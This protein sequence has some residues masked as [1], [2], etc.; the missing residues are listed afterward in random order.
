MN[1]RSAALVA[2]MTLAAGVLFAAAAGES[3]AAGEDRLAAVGFHNAGYPIVDQTVTVNALIQRPGHVPTAF[4]EQTL[5]AEMQE[6]ANIDIVFEEVPVAQVR[7]KTNLLFASREFPDMIFV[8]GVN[9]RLLW[10]AAQAGDVWA[11]N[12]LVDEY[13][14]NWKRAFEERPVIRNAISMPDGNYYSLPYYREILNDFGIRDIQAI[15]VDWLHTLGLEMPTTTEELYQTLK[16]FRQGIDDGTLPADS[17]PWYFFFHSWVG[18][19]WEI[20]NAFGLWMK[21]QGAGSQRYLS[22]NNGTVEFG[23]TDEKLK[24][25]VNYLHRLLSED[26]IPEEVF[27]DAWD[28]YLAKTR[29]V[30]PI[31][32]MWGSYF[33]VTPVEEWFD[34]LPPVAGPAGVQRFRSQPV[35]LQKNQF[36][37]FTKFELPEVMVRFI[38]A[39]ADDDFSVQASYG[40]PMIEQ[41]ADGTRTVVGR[42]T[43]WYNHGPHNHFPSYISK[44]ASDA[45]RWT[46]EQGFRDQ[47]VNEVFAPHLWPQDRHFAYITFNDEEQEELSILQT[48]IGDYVK[49]AIAGWIVDGNVDAEWDDYLKQLDRIDLPKAMEIYQAAYDRF[50]GN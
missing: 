19:E 24:D 8:A 23:A 38:D 17:I 25:A 29:S 34:P 33:I 46:G 22:V 49:R 13:A 2:A 41:G 26:L 14:P 45:V 11:L 47:Y 7:E 50:A 43:D 6:R 32:G 44:R 4:D 37:L 1:I 35:R 30:P 36:T 20:Y 31:T 12:D 28:D 16:A 15:N 42:G 48:E 9:D 5:I 39:W 3:A 27:T 18:G 21:G 10:D 40:G